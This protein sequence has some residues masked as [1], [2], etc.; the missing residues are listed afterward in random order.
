MSKIS[1]YTKTGDEG[2]TS[3][4]NGDRLSKTSEYFEALGNIDEL[5]AVI[6]VAVHYC[7]LEENNLDEDLKNIQ[8][9]LL[10]I[11]ASVATPNSSSTEAQ[12]NR[13]RFAPTHT[14]L[15]ENKIDVLS[16]LL[17]PLKNFILPGGGLAGTHLH[18][19]RAICRR[20]ERSVCKIDAESSVKIYL[21]RLS[22][23]LFMAAR[24]ADQHANIPEVIYKKAA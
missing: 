6:G 4:Y 12:L 16:D 7:F 9:R 22:D 14:G 1:I 2:M 18:V 19:A 21:N 5:N 3:L 13:T 20:A 17:P 24:I 15:L 11:G 10:D 8:S 23:Y